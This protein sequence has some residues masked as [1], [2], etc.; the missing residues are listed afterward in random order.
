MS[1]H[2]A[3]LHEEHNIHTYGRFSKIVSK[4]FY[5]PTARKIAENITSPKNDLTVIDL[6][7]G[8]GYLSAEVYSLL[9]QAEIVAV[10]PSFHVLEI[11]KKNAEKAGM[12]HYY[13]TGG[14]A[15]K[16]PCK[17]QSCDVV[18]SQSSF[19]EWEDPKKGL[20]EIFRVLK[21]GGFIMIIDFNRNWF[22]GW[23]GKLINLFGSHGELFTHTYTYDEV[24]T[25]LE[26]AGFSEP[27]GKRKGL[28][29]FVK[30]AKLLLLP[31]K[32]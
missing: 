11:A 28:Q 16:I 23:K 20:S 31:A 18:I 25:L 8:P 29:F 22:S 12:P 27:E 14:T 30:A 15:E 6:G 3:E 4:L 1:N 19:H 17:S 26:D 5:A 21:P 32:Y 7:S 9:P 24:V 10:D 13:V 2:Q